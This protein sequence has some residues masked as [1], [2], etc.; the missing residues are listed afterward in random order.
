MDATEPTATIASPR[1]LPI[2]LRAGLTAGI[3]DISAAALIYAQLG[4]KTVR[5]LQ[6]I[7][8]GLLGKTAFQGG[9]TTA[10]VGLLCHFTI[11]TSA[12]AVYYA[13][14]RAMPVLVQRAVPSG[15]VYAVAVYFFMDRVVV[16]LSAIGPRP[17]AVRAMVIG[18]AVHIVC[19]GLPISLTVRH[20]STPQGTSRNN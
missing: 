3:L 7:A 16:P 20:L 18:V 13:A 11:A 10:A 8:S 9:L 15:I 5:L 4:T 2:I 14:S 1:A 19:V 12:A 6:G 17:F